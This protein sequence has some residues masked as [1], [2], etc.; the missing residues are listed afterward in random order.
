M[1][2]NTAS[3]NYESSSS[4]A[5]SSEASKKLVNPEPSKQLVSNEVQSFV[6]KKNIAQGK[7]HN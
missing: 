6:Q 4:S 1:H 3:K 2:D 7:S 5:E